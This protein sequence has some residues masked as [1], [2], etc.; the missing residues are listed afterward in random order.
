MGRPLYNHRQMIYE[1]ITE[2]VKAAVQKLYGVEENTEI[3][4]ANQ[5]FG[6]FSSN[7]AF[8][9]AK[10]AK[11]SPQE[12]PEKLADH[13]EDPV[14]ASVKV[15]NGFLNIRLTDSCWARE[16]SKFNADY[17]KNNSCKGKR[18]Q[19]EFISA[20]PTGPL[21]LGNG[22]GGYNG[23]VLANVLA[24]NGYKVARE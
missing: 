17:L 6:D 23:D 16:V 9:L 13:I 1:K 2:V 22:R 7:I 10:I 19:V 5:E 8:K 20:N 21:T 18:V 24:A 11:K 3:T 4:Y 15:I 12:I 14:I